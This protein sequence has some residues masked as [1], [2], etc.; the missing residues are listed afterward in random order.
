MLTTG[1]LYVCLTSVVRFWRGFRFFAVWVFTQYH[2]L[3]KIKKS[4][5][6]LGQAL[7]VPGV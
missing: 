7:R 5:Y 2:I 6:S 1:N 3:V 4:H